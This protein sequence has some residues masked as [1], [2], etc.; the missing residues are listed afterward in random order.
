M[1]MAHLQEVNNV[2]D[3][4]ID[5]EVDTKR[6]KAD[7]AKVQAQIEREQQAH[8]ERLEGLK[9]EKKATQQAHDQFRLD[10]EE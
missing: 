8:R 6:L 3:K 10:R 2:R 9:I 4:G 5:C 1:E 7:C